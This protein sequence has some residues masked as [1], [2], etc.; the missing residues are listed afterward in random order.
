M[1]LL[2]YSICLNFAKKTNKISLKVY[3]AAS[4]SLRLLIG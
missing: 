3:V 1:T 4:K 2:T